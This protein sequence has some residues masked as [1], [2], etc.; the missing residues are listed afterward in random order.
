MRSLSIRFLRVGLQTAHPCLP[1]FI[2]SALALATTVHA[3]DLNDTGITG[4]SGDTSL[5]TTGVEADSSG[6]R[7]RQKP[8]NM[9]H[10][11]YTL[12]Y[13]KEHPC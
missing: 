6:S 12:G 3:V 4:C 5:V 1:L 10:L 7:L 8:Q 2:L 11:G 13:K 9:P